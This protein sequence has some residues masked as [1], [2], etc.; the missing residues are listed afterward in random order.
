MK[1]ILS[2]INIFSLTIIIVISMTLTVNP[3]AGAIEDEY[4]TINLSAETPRQ[5]V[6]LVPAHDYTSFT[7]DS[8][9]PANIS[10]RTHWNSER[11]E[12]NV[13]S[14]ENAS[15]Q[16]P[17][18][19]DNPIEP[20]TTA[21]K[22]NYGE[23]SWLIFNST[24]SDSYGEFIV[25]TNH[26]AAAITDNDEGTFWV[27][28]DFAFHLRIVAG[29]VGPISIRLNTFPEP[30]GNRYDNVLLFDPDGAL[31]KYYRYPYE[32]DEY[33][34]FIAESKGDYALIFD[35]T[36]E[37]LFFN[38]ESQTYKPETL[39]IEEEMKP[40][41][42][43]LT[44][45]ELTWEET[46]NDPLTFDW[47]K[48]TAE[49]DQVTSTHFE[50]L[51]PPASIPTAWF[52]PGINN[53]GWTGKGPGISVG[54]AEERSDYILVIHNRLARYL[55]GVKEVAFENIELY[56]S[57]EAKFRAQDYRA[58]NFS[59]DTAGSYRIELTSENLGIEIIGIYAKENNA[60]PTSSQT[61]DPDVE[62]INF[63]ATPG[64]FLL[65]L[66]NTLPKEA[67]LDLTI[68]LNSAASSRN[69]KDAMVDPWN[70]NSYKDAEKI[71][72]D[73]TG[74]SGVIKS[75]TYHFESSFEDE[76]LS[77]VG[78]IGCA[79][80]D[81]NDLIAQHTGQTI[82][83]GISLNVFTE[84]GGTLQ[85]LIPFPDFELEIDD[86][87]T[88]MEQSLHY[89]QF[90]SSMTS[91]SGDYWVTIDSYMT[92]GSYYLPYENVLHFDI[93]DYTRYFYDKAPTVTFTENVG[94]IINYGLNA[95]R[96]N[97]FFIE[98]PATWMNYTEV[99]M[100]YINGTVTESPDLMIDLPDDFNPGLEYRAMSYINEDPS[101][102][103]EVGNLTT[104]FG[105]PTTRDSVF[106]Q[107]YFMDM[108]PDQKVMFNIT[109][110]MINTTILSLQKET[111]V[112]PA[113]APAAPG[114]EW[115]LGLL[116]LG[117]LVLLAT[118]RRKRFS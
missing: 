52:T 115:V 1:K 17:F 69:F 14:E 83:V 44:D 71:E 55:I 100:N 70:L 81:S 13:L 61:I 30:V 65:I 75:K 114:F 21:G 88:P 50:V 91:D 59:V 87:G 66:H 36:D 45:S 2:K 53:T 95:S 76:R 18:N 29:A 6:A 41:I 98:V 57:E 26:T 117:T 62:V 35:P 58:Y 20:V 63:F 73:K 4:V 106:L 85:E 93:F 32:A 89:I 16:F 48:F 27:D 39:P 24:S 86:V 49:E 33:F 28:P 116:G 43:G 7:I 15:V 67:W 111:T 25:G 9:K 108:D 78:L 19:V 11:G 8:T 84:I 64:S 68:E 113:K 103:T 109:F 80:N 47:F 94:Q 101:D 12:F 105:T 46:L 107:F 110:R 40:L 96:Y 38:V 118:K 97:G 42:K 99:E 72:L 77:W 74:I 37:P 104:G 92:N 54:K 60:L 23:T 3:I 51:R 10:W 102:Y 112:K 22:I 5:A 90:P 56:A 79:F 82:T 34:I 31:V